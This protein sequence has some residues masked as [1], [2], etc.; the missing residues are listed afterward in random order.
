M[1]YFNT[2]YLDKWITFRWTILEGFVRCIVHC[3]ITFKWMFASQ[4][5]RRW[6]FYRWLVQNRI[7][8]K[9]IFARQFVYRWTFYGGLVQNRITLKRIFGKQFRV[10]NLFSR[11]FYSIIMYSQVPIKR[12]GPNK[13]VGW[14]F[15]KYFCLSLCLFLS[16]CFLGAK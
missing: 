2:T 9:W 8:L 6:T 5:F 15:I 3:R 14:I 16:S 4:F 12:V 1:H 11:F 13:R 10:R 7:T